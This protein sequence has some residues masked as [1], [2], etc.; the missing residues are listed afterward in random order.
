MDTSS[1][2]DM[3]ADDLAHVTSDD[4]I[5]YDT[6]ANIQF[7]DGAAHST[8]ADLDAPPPAQATPPQHA[9][10]G[11]TPPLMVLQTPPRAASPMYP[12]D[13]WTSD[14]VRRVTHDRLGGE[15]L[16]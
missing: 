7:G 8:P 2:D 11:P 15:L 6:F 16:Q 9:S 12:V 3:M 5:F 14:D 10:P 1:D 4:E 13:G